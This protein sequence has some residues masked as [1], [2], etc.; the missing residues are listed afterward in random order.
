[1][2]HALEAMAR[3]VVALFEKRRAGDA[4]SWIDGKPAYQ[5]VKVTGL[6]RN[7]GIDIANHLEV[8]SQNASEPLAEGVDFRGKVPLVRGGHPKQLDPGEA[9]RVIPYEAGR[10]IGGTVVDDDPTLR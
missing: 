3:R 4:E 9:P 10:A 6:E 2:V 8:Q 1:M 5:E 7:V